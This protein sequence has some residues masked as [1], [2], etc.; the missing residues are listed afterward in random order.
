MI[1][2]GINEFIRNIKK[3]ILIIIQMIAIYMISIFVV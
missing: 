1:T 3:N 2:L